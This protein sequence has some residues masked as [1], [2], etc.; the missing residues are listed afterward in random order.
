MRISELVGFTNLY[1]LL[2]RIGNSKIPK[3]QTTLVSRSQLPV[4]ALLSIKYVKY[5]D[6]VLHWVVVVSGTKSQQ[7]DATDP[8]LSDP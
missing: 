5:A 7:R 8:A 6:D 3:S 1:E 2:I 4:R